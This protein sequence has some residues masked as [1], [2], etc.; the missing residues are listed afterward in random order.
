[1]RRSPAEGVG[2]K[3]NGGRGKRRASSPD[4]VVGEENKEKKRLLVLY[5]SFRTP[6]FLAI[7]VVLSGLYCFVIQLTTV[8]PLSG[9]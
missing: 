6:V 2:R 9:M 7:L 3:Y 5:Y 4:S 1:V 8:L